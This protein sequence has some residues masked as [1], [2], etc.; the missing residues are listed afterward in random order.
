MRVF[1]HPKTQNE[2]KADQAVLHEDIASNVTIRA[3]VRTGTKGLGLPTERD[4]K[5]PAARSD[6]ARGK[7]GH[8]QSR[9]AKARGKHM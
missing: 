7:R 2:R 8:S 3:R 4:D 9:K 1:R 6:R 5:Y